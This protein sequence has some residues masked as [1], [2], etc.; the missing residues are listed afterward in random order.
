M[1][2]IIEKV[3]GKTYE[4]SLQD[5]ILTPLKMNNTGFDHHETILKNR[6]SGYE[7]NGKNFI[8]ASYLD[9]SIPY[10]A[11]S[12]YSTVD[13]LFLWNEALYTEQLL[14]KKNK[15]LLFNSYI[16]AGP[17]H[18]GY[19]W[20]INKAF[21]GEKNESITVIEHGGG[22]NGFNTLFSQIPSDKNLVVLLNNTGGT[23]LN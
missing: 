19:G 16:S 23:N 3:S 5:N 20:F 13:D 17:G 9:L 18:Y 8:N 22:I 6:A 7:K 2:Y 15:E 21:N 10:A 4:Q 11:G 12:L 14:S 1:G